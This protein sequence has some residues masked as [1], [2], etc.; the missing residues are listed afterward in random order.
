MEAA[1]AITRQYI[2]IRARS[3]QLCAHLP[4]DD[5]GLQAMP[6]TSPLKWHLAHVSWFFETFIL[7]AF[8][9]DYRPFDPLFE[10]LFNSY[11][12]GVGRPFPRP[13]RHLLSRPTLE[14]VYAYR[15]YVDDAMYPILEGADPDGE[16][17]RRAVIGLHHEMQHQELMLTDLKYNLAANP[18]YPAYHDAPLVP[19]EATAMHYLGFEGGMT[20]IGATG[21]EP[22]SFD[23]EHPRHRFWLEPYELASRPVTNGE[24]LAFIE[25]GGY[26]DPLLWLSDG[27]ARLQRE[28]WTHPLYWRLIDGEWFEFTLHGLQ[29]LDGNRPAVHLSYYEAEAYARWLGG[30]LPT[31][32]EWEHAAASRSPDTGQYVHANCLHPDVGREQ[33]GI[34]GLYGGVWEWTASPYV[35]YPGYRPAAGAIGEYNGKFMCNQQ[36]LRGGSCVTP[37]GHMRASYRN[38]FYPPDR[39]QF[40]GLRLARDVG[41]RGART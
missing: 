16:L 12:N 36:V 28:R 3:E 26:E 5:F 29:L 35:A 33:D 32:Q 21:D 8:D 9:A 30:R 18:L 15:R 38:F 4:A 37:P 23:N 13:M 17:V 40:S 34:R 19:V 6:E 1:Q 31:E 22:F 24:Y 41:N 25:D 20:D 39:W 7:K 10:M 2:T 27:W 11:Y 14:T